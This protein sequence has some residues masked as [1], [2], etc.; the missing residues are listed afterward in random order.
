MQMNGNQMQQGCVQANR[1]K[2]GGKM[3]REKGGR[4]DATE[5][6]CYMLLLQCLRPQPYYDVC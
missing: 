2:S 4:E 3:P 6:L 1:P 5:D